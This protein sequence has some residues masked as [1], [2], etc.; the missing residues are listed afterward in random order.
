MKIAKKIV[1]FLIA[2]GMLFSS[3]ALA[4][5]K[6]QLYKLS[7]Y[8]GVVGEKIQIKGINF[9]SEKGKVMFDDW[10]EAEI[11]SWSK[12]KIVIRVPDVS[13]TKTHKVRVCKRYDDD[14]CTRSQK[15]F[16]KRTGP[17]LWQIK[18]VN[19]GKMYSGN[20]GDK[21]LITGQNFGSGNI[22]VIFGTTAAKIVSRTSK[23]IVA[24]VPDLE[25]NKTYSVYVTDGTN[26]SSSQDFY[27]NP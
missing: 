25:R 15:F 21:A 19:D 20:P 23:K 4:A 9:G 26:S 24:I 10:T 12:K 2:G 14:D 22:S 18:R 1:P 27:V 6:P 11:V 7:K 5:K 16:V 8:K 13:V 17:E 3:A